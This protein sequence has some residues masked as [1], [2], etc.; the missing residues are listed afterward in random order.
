MCVHLPCLPITY[1]AKNTISTNKKGNNKMNAMYTSVDQL[2][3]TLCVEHIALALGISRSGAYTLMRSKGFP[4]I[5]IGKRM[6]VP[7][8]KFIKWMDD[9]TNKAK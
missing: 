9:Q 4:T 8:D 2:P 3:M 7:R 5:R 6:V 1:V